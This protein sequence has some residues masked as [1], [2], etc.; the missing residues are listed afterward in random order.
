MAFF[1]PT[2]PSYLQDP[3]P[4]L[5]RLR[6]DDPVFR[7]REVDGWVLTRHEDCAYVLREQAL[8]GNDPTI[9][10]GGMRVHVEETRKRSPLGATPTL[11][12][13]DPPVHARLRGLIGRAFT[14]RMV[15]EER[16]VAAK[17]AAALL[18]DAPAGQPF[19]FMSHLAEPLPVIV[20]SD[21]LG[22]DDE[23]RGPVRTWTQALMRVIAG[24]DL[25]PEAY[26]EGEAARAALLDF[27]RAYTERHAG[28]LSKKV[29]SILVE[30]EAQGDRLSLDEL[31]SFTVFLYTAGSGP[32]AYM[33][34]NAVSA[35]IAHPEALD[36]VRADRSL[37]RRALEESLRWDS[38]TQVLLRFA[39]ET[40]EV[41]GRKIMQGDTIFVMV[42]AA[43]RDPAMFRD[44]DRFD[45]TRPL[46]NA[47]LLSFGAGPHFC[48]GQPLA[49]VE[50][51]MALNALLDRFPRLQVAP[52]GFE[53]GGTFL[54]RGP[55]RLLL[56]GR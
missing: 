35:L 30:A 13:S 6:A 54:L 31:L 38:A 44:P 53:R 8:F 23:E 32:T 46:T 37:V 40:C 2:R 51:E 21:L 33:L 52:G 20:V 47:Q 41:G 3:Y 29:I 24:G 1:N 45:L 39:R 50:G 15:E 36:A 48:L 25:P 34:G 4:A 28:D 19:E 49:L 12:S 43:H 16:P 18:D 7:S 9:A 11:G 55:R 17:V 10:T 27:L 14:P 22:L 5:A 56:A 42:G 26:R